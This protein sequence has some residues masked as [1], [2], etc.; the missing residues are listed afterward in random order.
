M[1]AEM[2]EWRF[3]VTI[4]GEINLDL[5]LYGLPERMPLERELLASGFRVTLG[6][7]SAI[8]AHNLASLGMRVGFV[9]RVGTDDFGKFALARLAESG[10]DLSETQSD[11]GSTGTGVT[12][13]LPHGKERH[14]L[15]YLGTMAEMGAEDLPVEYLA[16]SRHF[17]L[18]S[19]FLQRALHPGLP[20]LLATLKR[21]GLTISL[22]TNDDPEDQW[23][24]IFHEVL[25]L[26]DILLPSE[27][28]LMH[29]AGVST[30]EEALDIIGQR[31]PLIVVKCGS[32]GAMVQDRGMRQLVAGV[33]V[34]PVDTIGAGDSF[35]AGFL[36]AYLRGASPVEAAR[37]GNI[38][39]ALSTLASGGT[40][41]FRDTT[42]RESFLSAHRA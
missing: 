22:D 32:R 1:T 6:S 28:E 9:T 23:G 27:A 17:H 10:V 13:L 29:M 12:I 3:D 31:V 20:K 11:R 7:S 41:A 4:A 15:T 37:M 2:S 18:S 19:L 34:V 30:L 42:L 14:I 38:T 24:G 5:I 8:V 40:E 36:S 33:S 16:S 21:A 35:N 39:G 26:I 25:G